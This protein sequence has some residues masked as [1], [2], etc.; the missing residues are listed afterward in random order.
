MEYF[1]LPLLFRL[2]LAI[3]IANVIDTLLTS[4]SHINDLLGISY[5][6]C[7]GLL[8]LVVFEEPPAGEKL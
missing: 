7:M 4:I 3:A 8:V 2:T 1:S 5:I 6:I